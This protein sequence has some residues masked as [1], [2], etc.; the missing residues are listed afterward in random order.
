[1]YDEQKRHFYSI[2]RLITYTR[3]REIFNFNSSTQ[4]KNCCHWFVMMSENDFLLY[5]VLLLLLLC[6]YNTS[7][8]KLRSLWSRKPFL[9]KIEHV[10]KLLHNLIVL[11]LLYL[12]KCYTEKSRSSD[13][14]A[15]RFY[16]KWVCLKIFERY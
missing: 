6:F 9:S 5:N 7:R 13:I 12:Q 1:M 15:S 11:F 8:N 14:M 4:K 2:T 3:T 16:T 10:L